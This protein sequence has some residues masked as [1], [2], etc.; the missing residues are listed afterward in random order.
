VAVVH[1][2]GNVGFIFA[3]GRRQY[4]QTASVDVVLLFCAAKAAAAAD[5]QAAARTALQ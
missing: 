5:A 2:F 1:V 3:E 4:L